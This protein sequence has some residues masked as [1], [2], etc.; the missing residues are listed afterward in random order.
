MLNSIALVCC[1]VHWARPSR[2]EALTGSARTAKRD[3]RKVTGMLGRVTR[4]A[5]TARQGRT[6]LRVASMVLACS[7]SRW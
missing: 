3:A 5:E 2:C 7:D 4:A 1:S 6:E